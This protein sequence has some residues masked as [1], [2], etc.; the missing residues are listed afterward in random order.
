MTR[1]GMEQQIYAFQTAQIIIGRHVSST[2]MSDGSFRRAR[3][4][5]D[6]HAVCAPHRL[7][8]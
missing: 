8:H 5:D 2:A 6:Q 1:A 7:C 3:R 4:S